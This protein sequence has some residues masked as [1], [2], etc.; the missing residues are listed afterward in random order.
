MSEWTDKYNSF[1][2]M[3][4]LVHV[5]Y[6]QQFVETG[7]IPSPR[8]VS[9]DP[10]GICNYHC[11][12][13]NAAKVL[14]DSKEKM[15]VQ[16]IDNILWLLQHWKTRAVC[17]GGGGESLLNHNTYEL[18]DSLYL[19][20]ID[21]GVVTNGSRID[22]LNTLLKCKWIGFSMD[23][24]TSKTYSLMKGLSS[25]NFDAV[26]SN[27]ALLTNK[28]TEISYKF[29]LHP[30]NCDEIYDACRIAKEIGC[31]LI[32]IRPGAE[33]WFSQDRSWV[34]STDQI[35]KIQDDISRAR[36]AFEDAEFRIF[37]ITHKFAPDYSIK[38]SFKKCYACLTTCVISPNGD[39]GL[40]CDRRGDSSVVLGNIG[41]ASTNIVKASG[42]GSDKHRAIHAHIDVSACPRCTYSHINEIF[43]NVII[44]DKMLFNMY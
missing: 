24:A 37:G 10:C 11:P 26:L 32:H 27:I 12:H 13:C 16:T 19:L 5:E 8:F 35:D 30:N 1:N 44:K 33:P 25:Y 7:R 14:T 36:N 29:L 21:I 28:G 15:S 34:F 9:I 6:W 31:N 23:A 20:G 42:W 2:S 39:V 4:A 18:I 43:E 3:K 22:S 17:I 40:C 41:T 38:K